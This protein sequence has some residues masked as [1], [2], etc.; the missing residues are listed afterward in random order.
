MPAAEQVGVLADAFND[1][2]G[3]PRSPLAYP[4]DDAAANDDGLPITQRFSTAGQRNL[5]DPLDLLRIIAFSACDSDTPDP[6]DTAVFLGSGGEI[7]RQF[8]NQLSRVL[9]IAVDRI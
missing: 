9:R 3:W 6:R 7:T 5:Q 8:Y 1:S 2:F 4:I